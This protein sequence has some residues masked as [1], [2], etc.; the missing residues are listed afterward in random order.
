MSEL[1]Y[2]EYGGGA[3]KLMQMLA[4]QDDFMEDMTFV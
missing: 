4:V 2:W 1:K 3:E